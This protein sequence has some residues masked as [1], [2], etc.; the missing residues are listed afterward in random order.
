MTPDN[1]DGLELNYRDTV[2]RALL[3]LR[4][5]CENKAAQA[6]DLKA[7]CAYRIVSTFINDVIGSAILTMEAKC[8]EPRQE[9]IV[10]AIDF[11]EK[12]LKVLEGHMQDERV[13][14][15]WANLSPESQTEIDS[16]IR[17]IGRLATEVE[18]LKATQR[19]LDTM[20]K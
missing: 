6:K 5:Y 15:N 4:A 19:L 14:V 8:L 12:Q 1:D 20:Q 17:R 3:F 16:W 9:E 13:A 7:A 10:N 11:A 18:L 2:A